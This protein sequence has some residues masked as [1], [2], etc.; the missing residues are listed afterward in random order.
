MF[1]NDLCYTFVVDLMIQGSQL[2]WQAIEEKKQEK[3]PWDDRIPP[4]L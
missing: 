4:G 3:G 2:V 1:L